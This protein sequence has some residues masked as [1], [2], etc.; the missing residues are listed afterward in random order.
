LL[1]TNSNCSASGLALVLCALKPLGLRTVHVATYQSVSGA[2]YPGVAS[3]DILGNVVPYIAREDEKISAETRKMLGTP[4]NGRIVEHPA[5]VIACAARVPTLFGHLETAFIDVET[6]CDEQRVIS[7]LRDFTGYEIARSLH[8][9]PHPPIEVMDEPA[10]PQPRLDALRGAGMTVSVG[11]IRC[12]DH[13]ISLRLLVN[14]VIRG[15]AGG[16][17]QNAELA[18]A[19]GKL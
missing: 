19:A 18:I 6:P 7:L 17:V 4:Q 3:L 16:S 13:T 9:S 10:R 1:I 12:T 8:S 2:G 11:G 14:N 15:A 5:R